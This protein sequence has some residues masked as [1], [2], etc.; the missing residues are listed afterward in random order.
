MKSLRVFCLA[1]C[2]ALGACASHQR[3]QAESEPTS[4]PSAIVVRFES[5]GNLLDGLRARVPT[6]AVTYPTNDCPRIMFRGRRS[7]R[8]QGNPSVYVDGTLLQDTC[9]LSQINMSDVEHVEVFP[10]GNTTRAGIQRNPF[11]LILVFRVR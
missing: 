9:V 10:S 6:M 3:P 4:D 8:N 5:S 11:G 2:G 7:G 1:F